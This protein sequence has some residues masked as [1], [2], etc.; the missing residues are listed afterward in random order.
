MLAFSSGF[1]L[2]FRRKSIP[3]T[4]SAILRY[5][6]RHS[7]RNPAHIILCSDVQSNAY[8]FNSA[9]DALFERLGHV[10]KNV[11]FQAAAEIAAQ[12][13]EGTIPRLVQLLTQHNVAHRRA[14]VQ[15]LG[16]IGISVVPT[17]IDILQTSTNPTSR[18]SCAKVLAAVVLYYPRERVHFS[19]DALIAM[20]KV[21]SNSPDPVT[22]LA[23]V[24]C[25]GT[26]GSDATVSE[27]ALDS[28]TATQSDLSN[29]APGNER[30]LHLLVDIL[31]TSNDVA[32]CASVSGALA[33]IANCGTK[34]KRKYIVECLDEV[35]RRTALIDAPEPNQNDLQWG[36][37]GH[38]GDDDN[39]NDDD[40]GF[41]YVREM[42]RN[43][44]S[45]LKDK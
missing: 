45:Q 43:H 15:C 19:D 31:K 4:F 35:A 9:Y 16:M 5:H 44:V 22:K 10:N 26:L 38:N 12:P 39:D 33:Q 41:D 18:A 8:S 34:E 1:A 27:D 14:A 40:D 36:S 37:I 2:P 6:V 17:I 29:Q 24:G 3:Q 32:L 11:S 21:L 30:S 42:C 25:L 23:I 28:S 13:P 20:E 7:P